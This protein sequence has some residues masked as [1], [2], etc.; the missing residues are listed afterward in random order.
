VFLSDIP[1]PADPVGCVSSHLSD[2]K[3]CVSSTDAGRQSWPKR[4]GVV[5]AAVRQ[6]G[7]TVVDT[8][9]WVCSGDR[10]P[11]IVGNMLVY[12]DDGG[13]LTNTYSSWLAPVVRPLLD[14]TSVGA[15]PAGALPALEKGLSVRAVPAN[16][17]PSVADAAQDT[18]RTG[19]CHLDFLYTQQGPCVFGDTTASRSVVLFGDSHVNQ[20]FAAFNTAAKKRHWKLVN[21]TK[22]ACPVANLTVFAP[23]LKRD[24][25]ECDTWRKETVAR[26]AVLHPDLI[27]AGQSDAVQ[28]VTDDHVWADATVDTLRQLAHA[29]TQVL[30]L[31][32]NPYSPKDPIACLA[33]HMK[34]VRPCTY[35]R[36]AGYGYARP[37]RGTDVRDAVRAAGFPVVDTSTWVCGVDACPVVVGTIPVYRDYGHVTN[38]YAKWLAPIVESL[39]PE[40]AAEKGK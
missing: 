28:A 3:P 30:M 7:A 20:W 5:A 17:K 37:G 36:S 24:Y 26:I 38:T 33:G 13:H 29:G 12:K 32:D 2:V 4:R 19:D 14:G 23:V 39:L 6:A 27:I 25:T 31:Q 11:P 34:D 21:W 10:C 15:G 40:P 8:D 1:Q 35:Q 18:P 22:A 9:M 16:L